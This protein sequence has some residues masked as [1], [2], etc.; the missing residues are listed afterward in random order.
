MIAPLYSYCLKCLFSLL[1]PYS[2]WC[3]FLSASRKL[4]SISCSVNLLEMTQLL[5]IEKMLLSCFNFT[6]Y[7]S[8]VYNSKL[9]AFFFQHLKDLVPLSFGLHYFWW[10]V[11]LNCV[12]VSCVFFLLA[13]VEIFFFPLI[14]NQH[15]DYKV[16]GCDFFIF[17]LLMTCSVLGAVGLYFFFSFVQSFKAWLPPAHIVFLYYSSAFLSPTPD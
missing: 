13:P 16:T 14:C 12:C 6:G 11:Q 1:L 9:Q 8:I 3:Y 7:F 10:D 2:I 15:F 4:F 17:I 5:F